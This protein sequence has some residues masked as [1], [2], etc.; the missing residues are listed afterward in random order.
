MEIKGVLITGVSG[1]LGKGLVAA[2]H[3]EKEIKLFG[4]S[5]HTEET[6]SIFKQ[7]NI[8]I[9]KGYD[10]PLL[11]QWRIHTIIHLAGIAH[12]LSN[13]YKAED[14]YRV[15][16]HSTRFLYDAFLKSNTKQFIFLSS[17]KAAVDVAST[18]V[19]ESVIPAPVS[20]YGKSK[21]DAEQY[22]QQQSLTTGKKFY[23]L[24]PC[25]IHGPGNKG[26]LNLLY[27]YVKSGLPFPLGAFHNQRSFLSVDNLNFIIQ[28]II[29]ADVETGIYH[30]ADE[31]YF[32]TSELFTLIASTL[33]RRSKV[34][35]LPK[36]IIKTL[37]LAVSKGA[38]L[39]KLTED[40]MVSNHKILQQLN[41][42][43][44]VTIKEGLRRTIESF[45]EH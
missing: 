26:N 23:I 20:H 24:R 12:D 14:Y 28:Q 15:N 16:D 36:G 6:Q 40:M 29:Q 42:P 13:Q 19:N 7:Y 39:N 38:M 32:S 17:I 11:D 10:A 21:L 27:K 44:P 31:G 18:P 4:H 1:F 43:L 9:I 8:E 25:M 37:F 45:R 30:L 22:I 35:H 5:R 41:G 33:G 3:R 34:W 2:L